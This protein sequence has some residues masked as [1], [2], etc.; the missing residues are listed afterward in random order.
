M[1]RRKAG[2][3]GRQNQKNMPGIRI[4]ACVIVKDEA[5]NLP[6][7]L[8]GM[9]QIADE[10]LVIDTGS[11]DRTA[12]LARGAGAKVYTY[13][14]N[15]DFAAARNFALSKVTGDWVLFLDADEYFSGESLPLVRKAIER[16]QGQRN[17]LGFACRVVNIDP[18]AG[19]RV[20]NDG[21][22]IRVFR[23]L[24]QLRYA[25]RVHE[26]LRYTGSIADPTMR[27]MDGVTIYHT[28]YAPAVQQEKA[29]R[30]LRILQEKEGEGKGEPSDA[31]YLADCYY[32]L[33]DYPHAAEQARRA[34]ALD[35]P[36][37]G[38]ETRPYAILLDAMNQMGEG[39]HAI[40]QVV[41]EAERRYPYVPSFRA[42][43]GLYAYARGERELARENLQESLALYRE[44]QA[45]RGGETANYPDEMP[46]ILPRVRRALAE[47]G[48]D[49][50]AASATAGN[51]EDI[52][53]SAAV[54][55]KDE[56]MHLPTWLGC[57]RELADEI[58]VVD[59]GSTD[60]TVEIAEQAGA[61]VRHFQWID[62]FAAAK[63]FAIEQARGR[64]IILMDAD[65]YIPSADYGK[66]RADIARYDAE[67]NVLGFI[68]DWTNI[69][70][71][72]GNRIVSRGQ[73]IRVFKNLPE[74]RYIRMIHERLNF[75]G[76]PGR[77][78]VHSAFSILHTGYTPANMPEKFRRNER[79][80]L[81][82]QK[83]YGV[84]PED[85]MYLADCYYG[86]GDYEKSIVCAK[87]YIESE[88][89]VQGGENRPYAI[90]MQA[91]LNLN[92]DTAE[93]E[94]VVR[95]ALAEF[96]W[97][98]EF[99][100]FAAHAHWREKDYLSAERFY[101]QA[102]ALYEAPDYMEK[103]RAVLLD[104]EASAMMPSV[105]SRLAKMARWQGDAGKARSYVQKALAI[106]P[107]YREGTEELL[108]E[109]EP[110]GDA[111]CLDA[112]KA[113]YDE[114]R[115]AAYLLDVMPLRFHPLVRL[116]YEQFSGE[117]PE[118]EQL[119]LAGEKERAAKELARSLAALEADAV[120]AARQGSLHDPAL[121]LLLP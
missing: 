10:I 15:D 52:C 36:L 69:N 25:G 116:Y 48:Q 56:E 6:R 24:P 40:G 74:L 13:T 119:F 68:S 79:L 97:N 70:P 100:I 91:L 50:D 103:C 104:E 7:W 65:E 20:L 30:N 21:M 33:A 39:L 101:R 95:R 98:A 22:H 51:S 75:T 32:A 73:Q 85:D 57:V 35:T 60:R 44:F 5:R 11:T 64:W 72:D 82:S 80:L 109:L 43:F 93:I 96:P 83:K 45:H 77:R 99:P 59:T 114:K 29:R 16:V 3:K 54:I 112:L 27:I 63:N 18:A 71:E 88:G 121:S 55:V 42:A 66:F 46:A 117:H 110:L 86:T 4:S 34:I 1:S 41:D 78:M 38:R 53:I 118:E 111:A 19:N 105:Y 31:F 94:A 115:D 84:F 61:V 62:D 67:E 26:E 87:R 108:H 81:A 89:R 37:P 92:R 90:W 12:E 120:R 28:G 2:K 106:Y 58:L 23:H 47:L 102:A 8:A 17:V 113:I 107:H 76:A 14:W 9:R 49:G